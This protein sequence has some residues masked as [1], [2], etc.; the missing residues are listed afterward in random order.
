MDT[1]GLRASKSIEALDVRRAALSDRLNGQ[2]ALSSEMA[3]RFEKVFD[4]VTEIV[5]KMQAAYAAVQMREKADALDIE[6][7]VPA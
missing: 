6:R 3:L 5:L 7:I 4:V 1:L 2:A